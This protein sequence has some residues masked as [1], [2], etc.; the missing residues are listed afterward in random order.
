KS[1]SAPDDWLYIYNFDNPDE[2]LCVRL[3][4]SLGK[5]FKEKFEE[6]IKNLRQNLK[7]AFEDDKHIQIKEQLIREYSRKKEKIIFEMQQEAN[8][9]GFILQPTSS[10]FFLSPTIGGKP[11]SNEEMQNLEEAIRK[12]IEKKEEI[13]EEKIEQKIREL[14]NIDKEL[15]EKLKQLDKDLANKWISF[16]IEEFKKDLFSNPKSESITQ[17]NL[18]KINDYL[19]R[20]SSDINDNLDLFL[21]FKNAEDSI[22]TRYK[23]NLIIDNSKL[24]GVPIVFEEFPTLENLVGKIDKEV[25]QGILVTDFTMIN[26]GAFHKANGGYLILN[27][28]DVLREYFA[29]DALKR[30]IKNKKIILEDI[31]SRI[32]I[33]TKILKPEPIPFE[34]KIILIGPPIIYHLLYEYDEDFRE[35]FHIVSYF[36]EYLDFNHVK[37]FDKIDSKKLVEQYIHGILYILDK[38][39]NKRID[40]AAVNVLLYYLHRLADS[41][42]RLPLR[43]S[44]IENILVEAAS[45]SSSDCITSDDIKKAIDLWEYR[46][47]FYREK[48][49]K[50]I[51]EDTIHIS[52]DGY[53][54]GVVNG[55]AVIQV[56]QLSFGKP[57]KITA[58][59]GLGKEGVI[60]IEKET[61]FSG[62]I[63]NKAVMIITG[64]LIE[65]YSQDFPLTL[66]ARI[67]FEQNYGI[68]EGDSASCAEVL[69]I[70]S[71]LS[72]VPV[73]QSIAITGSMNQ[74]GM[75]QPV[76]GIKEKIEGFFDI[77]K[78]RGHL[79]PDTGVIIPYQNVDDLVLK[80][81]LVEA[82]E[83]GLFNIYAVKNIDEVIEIATGEKANKVHSKVYKK[84]KE[85]FQKVRKEEKKNR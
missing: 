84:L 36:E 72:G 65:K 81:E 42:K 11:I 71:Q 59:A 5:I 25:I 21:K 12:E 74:K 2:P 79:G 38:N 15:F 77:C 24:E 34:G 57:S 73:K 48:V 63:H 68:M 44:E 49:Q 83:K 18:K 40:Y 60:S 54:V 19:E 55:L 76:G 51:I 32:G 31:H 35:Y 37:I 28:M 17:E 61:G 70:I 30:T 16:Y 4:N 20:V 47:S 26:P 3:P 69:A 64:Y 58:T 66:Q 52:T 10:G 1:K 82:V 8:S 50:L 62:Q 33:S 53:E 7:K 14:R 46:N 67:T 45:V 9:F 80:T 22:P 75:V 29:Y 78:Y 6:N 43:M 13:L 39:C 23:I 41:T 56:G 85:Y 27:I